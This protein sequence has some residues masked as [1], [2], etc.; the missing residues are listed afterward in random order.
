MSTYDVIIIGLGGMGSAAAARLAKR[1]RRVLGLEQYGRL[2][3]LGSSHGHSRIIREAYFEAPEYVPLVQRAYELWRELEA[4]TGRDLLEITGGLTIGAPGSGFVAGALASARL[5]DLPHELLDHAEVHARFPGFA[6]SDELVAVHEP[7]AGFLRPEDCIDAHLTVATRHGADLRFDEGAA[8]WQPDGDGVVVRTPR[9]VYRADRLVVAAGPWAGETLASLGLPLEVERIVNIHVEPIEP[10]LYGPERFP[11]YL[12]EAPEG[13]YY[14][15]PALPG[16]GVKIGRHEGGEITTP[17][18]IRRAVSDGEVRMLHNALAR[19][20][21]GAAGKVT[22]T[23][24]CMYTNTPDL[25]FIIDLVPGQPSVAIA[26]GFS[27]HGYKFA[28][29]VGE[30][31]ADLAIEGRTRHDTGFLSLSRFA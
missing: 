10:E 27:G 7:N 3:T 5:H 20:L 23:L 6:L 19:Y 22:A 29:V 13:Q 28:S 4:E 16:Q 9:G 24:T 31:M 26:C 17:R 1:G 25:H 2:H 14:G 21:P 8:T 30:V 15:F 12:L 18:T 11:V